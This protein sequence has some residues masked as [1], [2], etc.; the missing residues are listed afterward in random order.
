LDPKFQLRSSLSIST[1]KSY[2][3]LLNSGMAFEPIVAVKLGSKIIIV[4]GA[5]R[6]QAH[7]L[8]KRLTIQVFVLEGL[9]E[10]EALYLALRANAKHGLQRSSKDKRTVVLAMLQEPLYATLSSRKLGEIALVSHNFVCAIRK[11][12]ETV[13]PAIENVQSIDIDGY[14]PNRVATKI[15]RLTKQLETSHP[16]EAGKIREILG[17]IAA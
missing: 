10:K 8:E 9:G 6:Y 14:S 7:V 17:T 11:E 1:I 13:A 15:A 4:D 5:H 12:I 2:A 3:E 16:V